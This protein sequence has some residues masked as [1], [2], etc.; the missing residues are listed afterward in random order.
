MTRFAQGGEDARGRKR[1]PDVKMEKARDTLKRGRT[2]RTP[3]LCNTHGGY[4]CI[5]TLLSPRPSPY[6][7]FTSKLEIQIPRETV[8]MLLAALLCSFYLT[9][10]SSVSLF[11]SLLYP[12]PSFPR[13]YGIQRRIK[14]NSWI[15]LT[16]SALLRLRLLY[17]AYL[18]LNEYM[19]YIFRFSSLRE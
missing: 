11:L 1:G 8:V 10:A 4:R 18:H 7:G 13:S 2:G 15:T 3:F 16:N 9:C 14:N 17:Y 5:V 6:A 12:S 19:Y